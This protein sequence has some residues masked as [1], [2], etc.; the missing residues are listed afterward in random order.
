MFFFFVYNTHLRHGTLVQH[1]Q[2]LHS[3]N[4]CVFVG[5]GGWHAAPS[6]DTT[7]WFCVAG[8]GGGHGLSFCVTVPR[9]CVPSKVL[10]RSS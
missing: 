2:D 5:R 6:C 8:E 4:L 7:P 9:C 3:P 1:I 10:D